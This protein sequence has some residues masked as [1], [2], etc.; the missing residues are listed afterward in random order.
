MVVMRAILAT[1]I[2][3]AKKDILQYH[4]I[5]RQ[6]KNIYFDGWDGFGASAVLNSIANELSSQKMDAPHELRFDKVLYIDCSEWKS[7]RE[8]QRAIAEE[9]KLDHGTMAMF[10]N[11][12]EEDDYDGKDK[13]SRD[14]IRSIAMDIYRRLADCKFMMI[15]LNGSDNEIDVTRFGIP[16]ITEFGKN[17]IIW[18]FKRKLLTINSRH[19][20]IAEKLR[21][22][23]LFL[24]GSIVAGPNLVSE[25]DFCAL[26]HGEA[27]TIVARHQCMLDM[28]A[29]MVTEC[30]LFE[31]S[32]HYNFHNITRLGWDAHSSNYW[33]CAGIIAGNKKMEIANALHGEIRW[34]CDAPLLQRLLEELSP[35]FSVKK[36]TKPLVV[37][38]RCLVK[39]RHWISI[40]SQEHG[41]D[42]V[43]DIPAGASA[44]FLAFQRTGQLEPYARSGH[45]TSL[46]GQY[47]P[48][49]LPPGI[50]KYSR[51]IAVLV[52]SYCAFSFASPPFLMCN[53]LRFLGLDKCKHKPSEQYCDT[54]AEWTFL[55]SL[56]VLEIRYTEWDE[57][58]SK[59]KID[60][61]SNL[62]ELNI[63]GVWSWQCINQLRKLIPHLY[64]LRITNARIY[65]AETVDVDDSFMDKGK[66]QLL[67]L[68]GNREM[69]V[70]PGSLSK[71]SSLEVL[72]LD[73]C[74]GLEYVG[75][76][77]PSLNSFS[78]DG[79]GVAS[80]WTP[81]INNLLP[82]E[83]LRPASIDVRDA[84][85]SRICLE[86]CT[87][88]ENLFLRGLPNLVELDL[89]GTG[90]K[91][92]D[93]TTMVIQVPCLKRLFLLGCERLVAIILEEKW[94]YDIDTQLELL[95]IDTRAETGYSRPCIDHT[96]KSFKLQIHAILSDSRLARS[97]FS[98]IDYHICNNIVD[99]Y[100]NILVTDV[101]TVYSGEDVQPE[102]A[103]RVV[104]LAQYGDVPAT[105]GDVPMQDF[106]PAPTRDLDRHVGIAK[107]SRCLDWV[108]F[109]ELSN[110]LHLHDN[111][112]ST[113]VNITLA[114]EFYYLRQ[115]RV[116]RCPKLD[117]VFPRT[118]DFRALETIWA[119][120][121][122]MARCIWGKG[123]PSYMSN[124]FDA[125]RHLNLRAC[126]RLQFVLP[127]W[128][129]SFPRL[130]ML[131]IADCTDLRH[132]FVLDEEHR[133]ERIAFPNLKAMHLHNL[134]SLWQICE[135]SMLML[136]PALM[137]I[138]IRGCWSLRRL[139]SMEGR[140]V[141]MEK[142]TV[143]IEK[144]V[145]D[146]LEWDGVEAGHHPSLFQQPRHSRYYRKKSL[147]GSV[148]S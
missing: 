70:V 11:Q 48:P 10:D 119:S 1:N 15:F 99:I 26:V 24:Y 106:P 112:I 8:M 71:A 41:L 66:L 141:H 65:Q 37:S 68:S 108:Q 123:R 53:S 128:V 80:H 131:H 45:P 63:E 4:M 145:W 21:Y 138:K 134:P 2:E 76:L 14:V 9:L 133:E 50:F 137:T 19:D 69:K 100:F 62:K 29:T 36:I 121:L 20:E 110:S 7:R 73:G 126:P 94:P 127:V 31:L 87:G 130:E 25:Q 55:L 35:T 43:Q 88:L 125:L 103:H 52:L 6:K 30:C 111:D 54:D 109:I 89:S 42:G 124:L 51:S 82:P 5:S 92:L 132:V 129:S 57:I 17:T 97:L 44:V 39:D 105:A 77:P 113:G 104:A 98:I 47:S 34:E 38:M 74:L 40:T 56:W 59:E 79:Y 140:G 107:V 67:D 18:T 118:D 64:R 147:R 78:L 86:G 136:A 115:C 22:S 101:P 120:D 83:N 23:H 75:A 117:T 93:F 28:D 95:C 102:A 146:A 116:E 139:P 13:E 3:E 33:I 81:S 84:K 96:K 91:I 60:L 122:L 135:A 32:L 148:L 144:Y 49:I 142:P 58:L 27:T 16:H 61:M 46:E 85:I 114:G 12:D 72:L 90:I 143:E